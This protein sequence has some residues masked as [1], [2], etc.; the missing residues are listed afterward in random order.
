M[1][2]NLNKKSI[3]SFAIFLIFFGFGEAQAVSISPPV[4]E[5]EAGPGSF[6]ERTI[7]INNE[8]SEER[9]YSIGVKKFEMIG[10]E[11]KQKFIPVAEDND[12]D[13]TSWI[14]YNDNKIIIP[15][16]SARKFKFTV[17]VP[18][19]ADP[20]GHYASIY[21][22]TGKANLSENGNSAVGVEAQINSLILLRV[23]GNIVEK[24]EVESLEMEGGKT[25]LYR[26]PAKFVLRL[27]NSGN[28]HI[29][30]KGNIEIKNLFGKKVGLVDANIIKSRVLPDSIRKIESQWGSD[31]E[32][33]PE[34]WAANFI[35]ELKYEYNNFALGK[36]TA[37]LDMVYGKGNG[38]LLTR[39]IYFWVFPWKIIV[40]VLAL[41]IISLLILIKSIKRYNNWIISQ[42]MKK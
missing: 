26:L 33:Q 37:K 32:N 18:S 17:N 30:P 3:I 11:G 4:I 12:F 20:G 38:N 10:E 15:P 29:R 8:T 21:F 28:V 34:T 35:Q 36:Y 14:K 7:E 6:I 27:K 22:N 39:E 9:I 23:S 19:K 1:L 24:A 13:L 25:L 41:A 16:K 40:V 2:R 42:A 5:L 31:W